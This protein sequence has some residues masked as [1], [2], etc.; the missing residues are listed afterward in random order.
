MNTFGF[1]LES[2]VYRDLNIYLNYLDGNVYHFRD[3]IS[4]DE[5]DC[6]LE[7]SDGD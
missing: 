4:G 1:I 6:I 3:N 5:V 2:L 7:M